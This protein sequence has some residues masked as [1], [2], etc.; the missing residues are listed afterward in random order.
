[1]NI[2]LYCRPCEKAFLALS[3]SQQ[4]FYIRSRCDLVFPRG[5]V[6]YVLRDVEIRYVGRTHEQKRRM[7]KHLKDCYEG[8]TCIGDHQ[9]YGRANWMHDLQMKGIQ[10]TME[11]LY[12][13]EI[14]PQ[15]IEWER[16]Y[17]LHGLQQGW[18]LTNHESSIETLVAR[19]RASQLDFLRCSFES[20]VEEKFV[21]EHG[22]EAFVRRYYR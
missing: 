14:A 22:I 15:V 20:L 2:Y 10:P 7:Q 4:T 8:L 17:I 13:V 5:Q 6:V 21:S 19:A 3:A 18:Q 9:Y 1:M 12:D 16:R 11:V